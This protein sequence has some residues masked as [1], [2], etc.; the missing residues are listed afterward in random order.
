MA[1]S[2]EVPVASPDGTSQNENKIVKIPELLENESLQ[3][4]VKTLDASSFNS[5]KKFV[6]IL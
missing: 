5:K 4:M 1:Y 6:F 3:L 2:Q